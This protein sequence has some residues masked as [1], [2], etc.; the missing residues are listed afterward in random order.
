MKTLVLAL[1]LATATIA[2]AQ[3]ITK[4]IR[5]FDNATKETVGTVTLSGNHAYFRDRNGEHY[6]TQVQNPDG[7]KTLYDPSGKVI[8][9]E[10]LKLPAL[11]E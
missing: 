9:A 3:Q 11:P 5:L 7:T 10:S 1:T 8:S 6:A 2:Q 4:T